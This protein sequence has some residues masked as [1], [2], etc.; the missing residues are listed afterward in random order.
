VLGGGDPCARDA[1]RQPIQGAV[2]PFI[3]QPTQVDQ[4]GG[5]VALQTMDLAARLAIS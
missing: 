1:A 3:A 4:G 5:Q 2:Q